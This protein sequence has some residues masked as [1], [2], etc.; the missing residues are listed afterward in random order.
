MFRTQASSIYL[1]STCIIF[2]TC[3]DFWIHRAEVSGR[4]RISTV[5]LVAII[6]ESMA[7]MI[8]NLEQTHTEAIEAW[9]GG[10]IIFC[11]LGLLEFNIVHS[12]HLK[13]EKE[14]KLPQ[15]DSQL[16]CG[17]VIRLLYCIYHKCPGTLGRHHTVHW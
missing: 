14:E 7:V 2:I 9:N 10:C 16:D 5:C 12:I 4:T 1:S 6:T 15:R 3:L 17:M 8:I 11:N 13:R